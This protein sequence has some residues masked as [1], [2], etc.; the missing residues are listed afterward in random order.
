MSK[1]GL[2]NNNQFDIHDTA[3][4]II[5]DKSLKFKNT[6]F[7]KSQNMPK[8]RYKKENN[9]NIV[10]S[11]R[12]INSNKYNLINNNIRKDS[13]KYLL[14]NNKDYNIN[15]KHGN[16]FNKLGNLIISQSSNVI[17]KK[18]TYNFGRNNAKLNINK[19]LENNSNNI[20]ELNNEKKLINGSKESKDLKQYDLFNKEEYNE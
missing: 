13:Q 20:Y 18:Y 10:K 2:I 15:Q 17:N 16:T 1:Q 3:N 7:L 19:N 6:N 4:G 8:N 5:F 14:I 11:N 9:Y 12:N